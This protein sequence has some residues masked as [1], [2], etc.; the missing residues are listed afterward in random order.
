MSKAR[1]R[2]TKYGNS[3]AEK[4]GIV[5]EQLV[6]RLRFRLGIELHLSFLDYLQID[7]GKHPCP[8]ILM[9]GP[10]GHAENVLAPPRQRGTRLEAHSI[11]KTPE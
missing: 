5:A 11:S 7:V 10:P 3:L 2:G 6:K 1:K 9:S 8:S 4:S